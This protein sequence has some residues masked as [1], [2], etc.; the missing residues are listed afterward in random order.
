M[1]DQ[2]TTEKKMKMKMKI[3]CLHGFRT[4]GAFLQKQIER[5]DPT[6]FQ[7]FELDFPDG[8]FPA[9]GKSDIENIF[10][11]PYFEWFQYNKDFTVYTNLDKCISFLCDYIERNG[12]FDG[13]LGFSQGAT[14]SALL[15]G[16]KAQ[17]LLLKNHPPIRLF[18]SISGCKFRDPS[19]C[20]VAYKEKLTVKSAHL[21]G[22]N[23][24]LREPS[25]DLLTSF[26][27]PLLIR[28]PKGHVV[29]KLDDASSKQLRSWI[30]GIVKELHTLSGQETREGESYLR[31]V[32]K[33]NHKM[34][35]IAPATTKELLSEEISNDH[36]DIIP[37]DIMNSG[38]GLNKVSPLKKI[39]I[40]HEHYETTQKLNH[41]EHISQV[42]S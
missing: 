24:W 22:D 7:D 28:H 23:D 4:S 1:E 41:N 29:P 20:Q 15:I 21:I 14:I 2:R 38:H 5:W 42:H 9:A 12:P 34:N 36:G 10:P 30:S 17:G 33:E 39:D 35:V 18:I 19:I 8:I 40:E 16:Y 32:I 11:P 6:I 26:N 3:L 13:F 31:E 27:N 25:E 37:I